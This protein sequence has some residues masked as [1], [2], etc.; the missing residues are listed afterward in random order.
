VELAHASSAERAAQVARLLGFIV[1]A[2]SLIRWQRQERFAIPTPLVLGVDELA[3]R[4]GRSYGT[5]LVDLLRHR[6]VDLLDGKS[7]RSLAIWLREHPAVAVLARDRDD[8][9][10]LAGRLAAPDAL[11]VADRF[12]LVRNVSDAL[13]DL[14]RS[15]R[16]A[17]PEAA[18]WGP[19][20]QQAAAPTRYIREAP[21]K[22]GPTPLKQARWQAVQEARRRGLAGGYP[23]GQ[24]G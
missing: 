23:P 7:V 8:S 11:Q 17:I 12:H 2:D 4:R 18:D 19:P 22:P 14:L 1:S 20:T 24:W 13:Q 16:W 9:Y 5:L 6:P 21:R 15:R 10:A 3:L